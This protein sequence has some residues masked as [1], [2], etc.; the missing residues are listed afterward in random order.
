M[1]CSAVAALAWANHAAAFKVI[2]LPTTAWCA[3][4]SY[5]NGSGHRQEHMASHRQPLPMPRRTIGCRAEAAIPSGAVH[6]AA[7]MWHST[8]ASQVFSTTVAV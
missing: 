5:L 1:K 8:A 7:M 2:P 3:C 4:C 6:S